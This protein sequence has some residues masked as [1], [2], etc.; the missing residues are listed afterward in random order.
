MYQFQLKAVRTVNGNVNTFFLIM[1]LT[2]NS[3]VALNNCRSV[4][5]ILCLAEFMQQFNVSGCQKD[6]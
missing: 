1:K 6:F 4:G 5:L 2:S 3:D